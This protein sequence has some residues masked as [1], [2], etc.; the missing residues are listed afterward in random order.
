MKRIYNTLLTAVLFL[1]AVSLVGA[2]A[3]A[4][5]GLTNLAFF[6]LSVTQVD[7]GQ[8]H[9]YEFIDALAGQT[10]MTFGAPSCGVTSSSPGWTQYEYGKDIDMYA[11]QRLSDWAPVDI[12]DWVGSVY[13]Y[14]GIGY[15]VLVMP[16]DPGSGVIVLPMYQ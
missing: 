11:S 8:A 3:Y 1:G 12:G 6:D 16:L 15:M 5:D 10:T 13:M 4:S 14:G 9:V 7:C 2:T